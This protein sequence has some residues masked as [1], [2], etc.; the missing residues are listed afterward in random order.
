MKIYNKPDKT[1]HKL[2]GKQKIKNDTFY[3]WSQFVLNF[4][5]GRKK[6]NFNTLTRQLLE[7]DTEKRIVSL[8]KR[9]KTMTHFLY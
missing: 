7:T 4:V 8:L 5:C 9:S 2:L 6:V 1:I 3:V